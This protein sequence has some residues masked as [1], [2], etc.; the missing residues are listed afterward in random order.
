[1]SKT[2]TALAKTNDLAVLFLLY[3]RWQVAAVKSK[4]HS[5]YKKNYY[6]TLDI[7][8][9]RR[10]TKTIPSFSLTCTV[11]SAMSELINSYD[12]QSYI[13]T[14][15]LDVT[16]FEELHQ[17]FKKLF[18]K[19]TIY[20]DGTI[21]VR[22]QL[23]KPRKLTSK[24]C[25]ALVL[26][27]TRTRGAVWT[28]QIPFGLSYTILNS[29][30]SFGGLLVT[31]ILELDPSARMRDRTPEEWNSYV[32]AV[33]ERHPALGRSRVGGTVDGLKLYIQSSPHATVQEIF[34]NGWTH[35]HYVTNVFLFVP[36]GTIAMSAMNAPGCMHDSTITLRS[37]MYD[38]MERV[39]RALGIRFTVDDAFNATI[40]NF[41]I[42][43]GD[44]SRGTTLLDD[45]LN[46]EATSMR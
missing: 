17:Q 26:Y 4:K 19:Y 28:L 21:A 22:K 23:G 38:R 5:R 15:G 35:D 40:Y 44:K 12:D 7:F 37:G 11:S 27:W 36:D 6:N 30:I 32:D 43:S 9:R 16:T 3:R 14:T 46:R 45:I 10:R 29:W 18:V 20:R 8:Q 25:L 13:N 24:L 2:P 31:K 42:K 1:M 39:F 34:Y 33:G 41:L